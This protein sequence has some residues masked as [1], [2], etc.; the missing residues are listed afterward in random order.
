MSGFYRDSAA[1]LIVA[2]DVDAAARQERLS[3]VKLEDVFRGFMGT[4]IDR[5]VC[6]D[7]VLE[8]SAQD[9]SC[10]ENYQNKYE[11]D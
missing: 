3:R 1:A 10:I 4:R 5:M 2:G 6:G 9:A 7:A 8:H 11:L